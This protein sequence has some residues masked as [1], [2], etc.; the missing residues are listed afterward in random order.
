MRWPWLRAVVSGDSMAP[1]LRAGD[2][3]LVRRRGAI[4]VGDVV[5]AAHPHQDGMLV[6][7]RLAG[8]PGDEAYGAPL[9]PDE[10]WLS[11]DN[12]LAAP[13]DSRTYGP[14][15]SAALVGRVVGRYWPLIHSSR[16]GEA[17]ASESKR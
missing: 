12:R 4:G 1:G 13:E 11:S 8:G 5:V 6:V 2:H 14:V 7:K 10:Y 9:G 17:S 3:V 15:A 16:N